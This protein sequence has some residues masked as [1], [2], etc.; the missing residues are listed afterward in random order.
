MS[1]S[2]INVIYFLTETGKKEALRRGIRPS[3]AQVYKVYPPGTDTTPKP[4]VQIP[5]GD[6]YLEALRLSDLVAAIKAALQ[7]EAQEEDLPQG[8]NTTVVTVDQPTWERAS[9]LAHIDA[10]GQSVVLVETESVY[11]SSQSVYKITG[12]T[13]SL[14]R[15]GSPNIDS[16]TERGGIDKPL[17][18]GECLD[19]QETYQANVAQWKEEAQAK[20]QEKFQD[21]RQTNFADELETAQRYLKHSDLPAVQ[22]LKAFLDTNPS[23]E[24]WDTLHRLKNSASL[25]SSDEDSRLYKAK[26]EAEDQAKVD[27]AIAWV[28]ENLGEGHQLR[29]LAEEGFFNSNTLREYRKVRIEKEFPGWTE[30]RDSYR[31]YEGGNATVEAI[32]LLRRARETFPDAYLS[33]H[34]S[35]KSSWMAVAKWEGVKL[36]LPLDED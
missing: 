26:R 16:D 28:N 6:E 17:T 25:A 30:G 14:G 29:L 1:S 10:L 22:E 15:S 24:D 12:Y 11:E 23:I 9:R 33:Y 4:T 31:E 27:E 5:D 8:A 21:A 19:L 20:A 35:R 32:Q 3:W 7:E 2:F 13:S 36:V 18:L 34:G